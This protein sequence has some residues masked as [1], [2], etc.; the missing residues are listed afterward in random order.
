M[1]ISDPFD[2]VLTERL[3][4]ST[5]GWATASFVAPLAN[6]W[7]AVLCREL[8]R[9]RQAWWPVA[10]LARRLDLVRDSA[11]VAVSHTDLVVF[12][13][14]PEFETW[15]TRLGDEVTR[16]RR[17]EIMAVRVRTSRWARTPVELVFADHSRFRIYAYHPHGL[18]A[19]FRAA[20]IPVS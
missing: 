18:L 15:R 12:A 6:G 11:V 9:R 17:D 20:G 4:G 10:R 16:F 13:M 7:G 5:L 3:G 14:E 8:R 2:A 19:G 1:V